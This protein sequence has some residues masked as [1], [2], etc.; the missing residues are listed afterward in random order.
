MSRC[1]LTGTGCKLTGSLSMQA[2]LSP[3][4]IASIDAS[5]TEPL[6]LLSGVLMAAFVS[7][8]VH[9]SPS[10]SLAMRTVDVRS[11]PAN[12][13]KQ[14]PPTQSGI[15]SPVTNAWPWLSHLDTAGASSQAEPCTL[16]SVRDTACR[17]RWHDCARVPFPCHFHAV[18]MPLVPFP[19]RSHVA[20]MPRARLSLARSVSRSLPLRAVFR[21]SVGRLTFIP[22][23]PTRGS[24]SHRGAMN[25]QQKALARVLSQ[26]D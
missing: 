19:C 10:W 13:E 2:M 1:Q 21:P 6:D 22:L 14:V 15:A 7:A 23:A 4:T 24:Q 18:P 9:A 17:L 3:S 8:S 16:E 12:S 20:P 11:F 25:G 26:G 5:V